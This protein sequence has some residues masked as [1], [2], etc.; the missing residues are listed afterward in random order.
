MIS[1][2]LH[3]FNLCHNCWLARA[4]CLG[5][6]LYSGWRWWSN[7][8]HLYICQ[9]IPFTMLWSICHLQRC[10]RK[11]TY[12][13]SHE[14][15]FHIDSVGRIGIALTPCIMSMNIF[16]VFCVYRRSRKVSSEMFSIY[17][18]DLWRSCH[19]CCFKEKEV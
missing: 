7:G 5:R 15:H 14:I 4:S 18:S 9:I 10:R 11:I 8:C 12:R 3:W 1:K 13:F 17:F 19:H 6:W 2:E 16:T